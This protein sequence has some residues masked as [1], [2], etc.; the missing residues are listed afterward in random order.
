MKNI[1]LLVTLLIGIKSFA[2]DFQQVYP[3]IVDADSVYIDTISDTYEAYGIIE[4]PQR[5]RI[6]GDVEY[7]FYEPIKWRGIYRV[8]S[9][10]GDP[11]VKIRVLTSI[12]R[13]KWQPINEFTINWDSPNWDTDAIP[14]W[15]TMV[16]G[17]TAM[18]IYLIRPEV[19]L[20]DSV[21]AVNVYVDF[22]W[23]YDY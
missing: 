23:E 19:Q 9:A 12:D 13:V 16:T 8:D 17:T 11:N 21:Q 10:G 3:L 1:V 14:F 5:I 7:R 6:A 20:L 4:I 18:P 15:D 22:L 2:Q